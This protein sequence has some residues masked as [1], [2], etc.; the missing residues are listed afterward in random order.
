MGTLDG[1][2][3]I[4]TGA[5][6]GVGRGHALFLA[7]QGAKVVVNDLG[8]NP[9]GTGVDA[10]PAQQVADEI[11][12]AGGV[13]VANHDSVSSWDGAEGLVRQAVEAF[14]DLHAVVNNAGILRDRMLVN[15]SE[16]EWDAVVDVHLKGTFCVTRFAASY[17][18]DQ[19]K[20]G[21]A[22]D[23]AVVNTASTSG[24]FGSAG[25]TNY[26][27]AKSAIATFS[28]IASR[29]LSRY[30]VRVNCI[31]PT[32][33]TRLTEHIA[34]MAPKDDGFDPMD[35]ANISPFIGYLA[36][37]SCRI[38][39]QV[40]HVVGGRVNLFKPWEVVDS[41]SKNGRWT[42]EEL[43]EEADRFADVDFGDLGRSDM[44]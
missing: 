6:R 1:R 26:G 18:R 30:G 35:P 27:S 31:A 43:A 3:V 24:L 22:I 2:V 4:V 25:Q 42:I 39:G 40:F 13:A 11:V 14:G 29:E 38:T 32:A 19:A 36:T 33:R 10:S 17:W 37:E 23:R 16:D 7:S 15:M 28:I 44:F 8:G 41:I 21:A 34:M 9:D 5:G 12:A 20:G